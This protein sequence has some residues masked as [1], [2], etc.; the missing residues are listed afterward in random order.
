MWALIS[1]FQFFPSIIK[2][3]LA[4]ILEFPPW[5]IIYSGHLGAIDDHL[6]DALIDTQFISLVMVKWKST[7]WKSCFYPLHKAQGSLPTGDRVATLQHLLVYQ[8]LPWL[9][10]PSSSTTVLPDVIPRSQQCRKALHRT[11][12]YSAYETRDRNTV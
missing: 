11:C 1:F 5:N 12:Q 2:A 7:V 4:C 6:C 9:P 3:S 10:N 8:L